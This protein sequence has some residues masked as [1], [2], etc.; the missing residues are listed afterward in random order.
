MT[1]LTNIDF[2][3]KY[4]LAGGEYHHMVG[5]GIRQTWKIIKTT[6]Y[7]TPCTNTECEQYHYIFG[8][9]QYHQSYYCT[10]N[11]QL[12]CTS[13]GSK[14]LQ[15]FAYGV[16]GA[17]WY[18]T[19]TLSKG[20]GEIEKEGT[21]VL[22]K[23]VVDDNGNPVPV[24][25]DT[26][27][28]FEVLVETFDENGTMH[29][30]ARDVIITVK[31]G[32]SSG[33]QVISTEKWK[34]DD[35]TPRYAIR[36]FEDDKYNL[37][38]MKTTNGTVT[39]NVAKGKYD[40]KEPVI[41]TAEN[42]QKAKKGNLIIE[43]VA[44]GESLQDKTFYFNIYIN[45]NLHLEKVAINASTDWM[46][47][48]PDY[49]WK[50]EA[51]TYKVE[52]VT[53][54]GQ[55][56]S[57]DK[58]IVSMGSNMTGFLSET[59]SEVK[60]YA[61]V[62][63]VPATKRGSLVI[64]KELLDSNGNP[65]NGIDFQFKVKVSGYTEETVTVTSGETWFGTYFWDSEEPPV[66]TVTE[67]D[68]EKYEFKSIEST[69]GTVEGKTV[70]GSLIK[71]DTVTVKAVNAEKTL[72]GKIKITKQI[73]DKDGNLVVA[74][75][76]TTF[77]FDLNITKNGQTETKKIDVTVKKG[78]STATS[79]EYTYT[80]N[81]NE[82][83][84]TYTVTETKIKGQY[85]LLEMN[86][87]NGILKED[88]VIEVIAKNTKNIT[89]NNKSGKIKITKQIVD[90]DGNLLIADKD[91]TFEF[92]L[93]ITK[94]LE[95]ITEKVNVTVKAGQSTATSQ[96]LTYYWKEGEVAPTYKVTETKINGN[97]ELLKMNNSEGT[98]T[99]NTTVEVIAKNKVGTLKGTI[100]I[101]K[102]VDS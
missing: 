56:I 43:K 58:D 35:Q 87:A 63:N 42:I 49:T 32:Q 77:G 11:V 53:E 96:E 3:F 4:M 60:A 44:M 34:E 37:V 15:M 100:E 66:Y 70:T 84:P 24:S 78:E 14:E 1:E 76:D 68:N 26:D 20:V 61:N 9:S 22:E 86:N 81:K 64:E 10:N 57:T 45:G 21:L 13:S 75:E 73:V 72:E 74:E 27:F 30:S 41:V 29:T 82:A 89:V 40:Y 101:F 6:T 33:K 85:K 46:Y 88:L 99:E 47:T 90:K 17:R 52:E 69:N 93:N 71:D 18:E 54:D 102:K 98:L 5:R 12:K 83:T 97:Y 39:E 38:I 19:T 65:I 55:S 7:N 28:M 92:D 62:I 31:K 23:V 16:N 8:S 50:G 80:W 2:E 79:E 51:P 25:E 59:T 67:C 95:T 91:T 36:E 94:G 48:M